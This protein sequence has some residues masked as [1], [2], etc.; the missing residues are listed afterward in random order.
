LEG[1]GQDMSF[2]VNGHRYPHYYLLA[3]G[4]YPKLT[5]F[6]QTI[7]DSQGEKRQYYANM[8]EAARKDV[9]RCFGVLQSRW[10]IIQNPSREWNLNTIKD[11]LMACVIMHNMIIEDERDQEL[12]PIIAEPI[13]VPWRHGPMRRGLN[14]EDYVQGHEMIRDERSHYILRNDLMEHLWALKGNL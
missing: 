5:I 7:H 8:Q 2:E 4:I 9:E 13:N 1:H 6:V 14:F 3:H 11:I 10:G 12:E